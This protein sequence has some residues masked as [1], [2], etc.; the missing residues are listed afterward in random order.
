MSVSSTVKSPG[1]GANDIPDQAITTDERDGAGGPNPLEPQVRRFEIMTNFWSKIQNEAIE[2]DK[3]VAGEHWPENIKQERE[4]EGRPCLTYNLLPAFNRQITNRMRQERSAIKVEPVDSSLGPDPRMMNTTGTRD[5]SM[6]D[7]YG[8][9]IKNIEHVSR[10]DQAYDTA[11]KH[12]VDHGFGFFYLMPQ[13]SK[14]DPFVQDLVIHRVK[15]SYSVLLDPDAQE[16][17]YRDMQDAFLFSS[18]NRNTFE[19]KYP[20]ITPMDFHNSMPAMYQ[21]WYDPNSVRIAQYLWLDYISDTALMLSNGKIVYERDVKDVLDDIEKETGVHVMQANGKDMRREVK[22]PVCMW[23]KM[24]A[25]DVIEG[26][27]ELPFSAIPIFPV[28]GEEIIVEGRTKYESAIRHAKDPQQ[29]YNYWRTASVEAAALAPKVP[30]LLTEQQ[31]E[32]HDHLFEKANRSNLP[33]LTYKYKEGQPAPTRTFPTQLAAAELAQATQDG[34]DIQTIIGLHDAN[35]GKK[36]N[37]KSGVAIQERKDAGATSTFQFPD[38][39]NRAKEQCGRC[40][41]E[42]IPKLMDTRR[43]VRLRLPDN[44]ND[45]VE[46]NQLVEDGDTGKMTLIHDIAYG[47]YDVIIDTGPSYATQRQEAANLQLELL[48]VLGPDAARNIVHLIVQNLGVPGS[49]EV[50]RVLRKMLPDELKSEE[51]IMADLPAG[52]TKDPDSGQ[53]VDEDGKPYQPPLTMAMQIQMKTNQIEEMKAQAELDKAA[54]DKEGAAADIKQAEAKIA[55]AEAKLATLQAEDARQ[56]QTAEQLMPEISTIIEQAMREHAI[57]PT[58]HRDALEE[59]VADAMVDA[60]KRVRNYVDK[61][62]DTIEIP[63]PAGGDQGGE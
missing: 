12:A 32:G 58:A 13:W 15:N 20:D 47:K 31:I 52:V 26:P 42:A 7:V 53:L 34:V 27:L 35:L 61:K 39:L 17:E 43:I 40:I 38:N 57:D 41:V 29:S 62:V 30:W 6:A 49:D 8:G 10:A 14:I 11:A 44:T 2:D 18:L 51:E 24:T 63:Q 1:T 16:S 19:R 9:V 54:A 33:F 55:E 46:I 23:Q 48:K 59:I 37:E 36:S 4:D 50:A 21:G 22:R 28:F 60:L 3:F 5:Y 45:F 56:V 25:H